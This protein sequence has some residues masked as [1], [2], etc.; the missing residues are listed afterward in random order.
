M[1]ANSTRSKAKP[2]DAVAYQQGYNAAIAELKTAAQ[3]ADELGLK[4]RTFQLTAERVGVGTLI[5]G[6]WLF[7]PADLA[8]IR[9][10]RGNPNGTVD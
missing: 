2:L 6:V 3:S 9:K 1:S 5:G 8:A 10:Y 4:K 7:T